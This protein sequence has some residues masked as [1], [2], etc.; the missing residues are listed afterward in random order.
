MR[1]NKLDA[2]TKEKIDSIFTEWDRPGS[3]GCALAV[4]INN[5]VVY[6]KGYGFAQLEYGI[7]IT[8]DTIFH[9]ASV[10]KQFT[11]MAIA[12]LAAEGSVDLAA[13]VHSYLPEL[14][15]FEQEITVRQL[16]HHTSG[17]RDQWELLMAAG[18]RLDDVITQ[19][20]LLK[21]IMRQK[22]LNFAPGE[23]YLYCNSGYTL[24]AEIVKRVTGKTLRQFAA[25]RIFQPLGMTNT[26]FHDDHTEIVENRAYSYAPKGE[27][28]W[29][30]SI[31]SYAAVGATSVFTTVKDLAKWLANF[32][33]GKVGGE[34]VLK[35]MN[36]RYA[37]N[38]GEEIFYGFGLMFEE[39]KGVTEI[40]H[41]GSDA[42]FRSWCG[43]VEPHGLGI[44]I[45]ANFANAVPREYARR[46]IDILLA[47]KL[48]AE[49]KEETKPLPLPRITGTFLL[50][51]SGERLEL[52]EE[53]GSLFLQTEDL[54]EP[55]VLKPQGKV[56][57]YKSA[58]PQIEIEISF[59]EEEDSG[60]IR[61]LLTRRTMALGRKMPDYTL[62]AGELAMYEGEYY[63][64]ELD[65]T[66]R[67]ALQDNQLTV[68]FQRHPTVNLIPWGA[69]HFVYEKALVPG[70]ELKFTK[71][72]GEITGFKLSGGRIRN[73]DFTKK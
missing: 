29:R 70:T 47:D 65:S 34:E 25:E 44:S 1:I 62:T 49:K 54:P 12:L 61:C 67:I 11:T 73:V 39:Y 69:A 58:S 52:T 13:P 59:S 10:S 24:L 43:R 35:I 5:E 38:N 28:D 60:E 23:Q 2:K 72:D 31:L 53:N 40:G 41:S 7:P 15:R 48:A 8:A 17:L 68:S 36:S 42:G 63:S 14:P 30:K 64:S 33:H 51:R 26:H 21:I 56:N 66:Y 16:V 6:A 55:V 50:Q 45:L 22:D 32:S 3:P 71:K 19:E 57:N 18:W 37:L 46:I 4:T 20:H 27:K 9:V